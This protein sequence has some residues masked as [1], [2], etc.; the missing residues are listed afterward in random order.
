MNGK[1]V[2]GA[3]AGQKLTAVANRVRV[4]IPVNCQKG[5]CGTC[6]VKLNGRQVKG[7]CYSKV[8]LTRRDE[9]ELDRNRWDLEKLLPRLLIPPLLPKQVAKHLY[10]Q[11]KQSLK[12]C[13]W[14]LSIIEGCTELF[15]YSIA[16]IFKRL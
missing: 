13:K 11:V 12:H 4:K 3:V 8:Y 7:T 5:D 10:L 1:S 2:P 6:M 16:P 9:V 14:R 15:G